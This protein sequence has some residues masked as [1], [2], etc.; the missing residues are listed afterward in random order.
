MTDP[1]VAVVSQAI[2]DTALGR[3]RRWRSET[4]CEK[5]VPR[6]PHGLFRSCWFIMA[7]GRG[8]ASPDRQQTVSVLQN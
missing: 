1:I 4:N 7:D 2:I 6:S 8:G 3:P 5:V